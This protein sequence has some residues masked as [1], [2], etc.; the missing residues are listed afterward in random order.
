[1][2]ICKL[3]ELYWQSSTTQYVCILRDLTNQ[4]YVQ[5]HTYYPQEINSKYSLGISDFIT[6][7]NTY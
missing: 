2:L 5:L 7:N 3:K 6:Q 4:I 1:M